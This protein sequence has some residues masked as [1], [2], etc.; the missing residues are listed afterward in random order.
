MEVEGKSALLNIS[1]DNTDELC[2]SKLGICHR[3]FGLS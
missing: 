2:N 1:A 3:P